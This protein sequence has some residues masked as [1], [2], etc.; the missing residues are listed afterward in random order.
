MTC[1]DF[2]LISSCILT[3][4]MASLPQLIHRTSIDIQTSNLQTS[5]PPRQSLLL[6]QS[7]TLA[8]LLSYHQIADPP[9]AKRVSDYFSAVG[10][11]RVRATNKDGVVIF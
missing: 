10:S 1:H 11:G 5:F 3:E 6:F 2:G 8:T 9:S 4:T 7:S